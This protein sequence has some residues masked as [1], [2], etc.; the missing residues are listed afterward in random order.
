MISDT[1]IKGG[2]WT[3]ATVFSF[4]VIPILFA[5]PYE[6]LAVKNAGRWQ[7]ILSP[8]QA[9]ALSITQWGMI[10]V[11]FAWYT[12]RVRFG[13]LLPLALAVIAGVLAAIYLT[14]TVLGMGFYWDLWH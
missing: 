7:H 4:Y 2:F 5:S 13:L 11:A 3:A 12:R 1:K 6:L 9:L 10:T 8:S 14:V